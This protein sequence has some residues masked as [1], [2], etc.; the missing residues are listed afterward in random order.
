MLL[1]VLLSGC[2]KNERIL[3]PALDFRTN[4][5]GAETCKFSCHVEADYGDRVYTF[6]L[7]CVYDGENAEFTVT[8]PET[9]AGIQAKIHDGDAEL[10]FDGVSLE[11]GVL[12]NGYVAPLKTPWI[13]GN[14]WSKEYIASAW[15][16][17]G[18][19]CFSV[20][21]GYDEEELTVNTWLKDR[22]PVKA[23]VLYEGKRV[24]NITIENFT[25]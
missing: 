3:Q 8:A 17:D 16:E 14:A 21:A 25:Y 23:E 7:D 10:Q 22:K 13:L 18:Y 19:Y 5:L 6:S 12:A 4:V 9:I 15:E 24:L 2:T 1:C 11:Y 20:L